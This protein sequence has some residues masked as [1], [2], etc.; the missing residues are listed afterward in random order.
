LLDGF[1]LISSAAVKATNAIEPPVK[2]DYPLAS[3]AL[4]KAVDV[5]RNKRFDF[6]CLLEAR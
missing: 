1:A 4:M 5:L 6:I 3:C 2:I